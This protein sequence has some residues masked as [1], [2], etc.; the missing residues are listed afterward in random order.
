MRRALILVAFL[1]APLFVC[2]VALSERTLPP[3]LTACGAA[4]PAYLYSGSTADFCMTYKDKE[5][6]EPKKWNMTISSSNDQTKIDIPFDKGA[7]ASKD[8]GQGVS[9]TWK[10]VFETPGK[11]EIS[12]LAEDSDGIT[13]YP[14]KDKPPI[15]VIVEWKPMRPLIF[16]G[17]VVFFCIVFPYLFF[18][19]IR[20]IASSIEPV[21]LYK[22]GLL[23]G[24]LAA[25]GAGIYVFSPMGFF[26]LFL[27][28]GG[29]VLVASVII[30]IASGKKKLEI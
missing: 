30:I 19:A 3:E 25:Y 21:M 4:Y 16:A 14:E 6:D 9:Y 1:A 22:I 12:F 7:L 15:V 2:G 26:L 13:Q 20:A 5:G 17:C 29:I 28:I 8:Y 11:Y 10:R 24:F 27:I 23:I 18:L